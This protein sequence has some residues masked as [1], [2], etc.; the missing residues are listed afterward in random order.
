MIV[1]REFKVDPQS[2]LSW[3]YADFYGALQLLTEERLGK[4]VR[5]QQRHDDAKVQA[6]HAELR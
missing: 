5:A 3:S 4:A 6:G 2:P 1:A